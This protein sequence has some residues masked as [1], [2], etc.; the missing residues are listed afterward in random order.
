MKYS[1]ILLIF[2]LIPFSI[3]ANFLPDADKDGV[4]DNDEIS[5]YHTDPNIKDTDNDGYSD[6]DEIIRGYSP[7]NPDKVKMNEND[8]DK[9]GLNDKLEL[10]FK[11]D[12][13]NPDTDGDGFKDGEEVKNGFNPLGKE[14]L[15][16]SIIVDLKNQ[17]L[18]YLLGGVKLGDFSV[19]SGVGNSTPR[20][21]FKIINKNIKAWSSYGLWMPYWMGLG[22]GR[23][24]IHELPVWPGGRREGEDHLGKPAS[25]GCIRL[26]IG[27][28]KE[29]YNWAEVGTKVKIY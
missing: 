2:F 11:T 7:H 24:G 14:K 12:L 3:S 21:E 10:S 15:E 9:D 1:I 8:Y 25:H 23:F 16:K 27:S 18:K 17:K 13:T 6:R 22:N 19:S 4:P 26:G 28:A 20:G 29:L 5:L